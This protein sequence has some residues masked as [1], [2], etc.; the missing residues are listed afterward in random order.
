MVTLFCVFVISQCRA[1][2]TLPPTPGTTGDMLM[3]FGTLNSHQRQWCGIYSPRNPYPCVWHHYLCF[4]FSGLVK[5]TPQY[6]RQSRRNNMPY[7][8]THC[9]F[10]I[11]N[12]ILS[13]STDM[14]VRPLC[15]INFGV[16][17]AKHPNW[18]LIKPGD[19][20][21]TIFATDEI[22]HIKMDTRCSLRSKLNE[23]ER[24]KRERYWNVK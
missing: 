7:F 6:P 23:N 24:K 4:R 9:K 13:C 16:I 12:I 1:R 21:L 2:N 3:V 19:I 14:F 5:A 8:Q 18:T 22:N 20:S 17:K 11:R 15:V 10:W